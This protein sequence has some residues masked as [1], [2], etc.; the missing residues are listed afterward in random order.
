[1]YN[2]AARFNF[3]KDGELR[4]VM[5]FHGGEVELFVQLATGEKW[6]TSDQ[7]CA[8]AFGFGSVTPATHVVAVTESW[9][10]SGKLA[11]MVQ[12]LEL[13]VD[14]DFLEKEHAKGSTWVHTSLLVVIA[15]LKDTPSSQVWSTNVDTGTE[16]HRHDN[17]S[18]PL[19]WR[20]V[21]AYR[22]GRNNGP[23]SE[24]KATWGA[25]ADIFGGMGLIRGVVVMDTSEPVG[26]WN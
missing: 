23:P 8:V 6:F 1:M 10:G 26:R 25:M 16:P 24:A 7:F 2:A 5:A 12:E 22:D 9:E 15:D 3:L 17:E 4:P 14:R 13:P 21:D 11:K 20:I 18:S 19:L